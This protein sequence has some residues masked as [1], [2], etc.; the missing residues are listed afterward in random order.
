M[1][2]INWIF[3]VQYSWA[4]LVVTMLYV[5]L[6]NIVSLWILVPLMVLWFLLVANIMKQILKKHN[7]N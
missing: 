5:S 2:L 7:E 6:I 3:K 4:D 1:K